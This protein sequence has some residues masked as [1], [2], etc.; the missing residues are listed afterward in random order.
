MLYIIIIFF[1]LIISIE[2]YSIIR[3]Y[4]FLPIIKENIID[5]QEHINDIINFTKYTTSESFNKKYNPGYLY[6]DGDINLF[7]STKSDVFHVKK[8]NIYKIN[9]K[10]TLEFININNNIVNYYYNAESNKS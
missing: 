9:S 6:T 4:D 5:K 10:F 3:I 7:V 1:I 2:I 8:G